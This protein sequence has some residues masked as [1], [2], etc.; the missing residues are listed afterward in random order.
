MQ[1]ERLK[2]VVLRAESQTRVLRRRNLRP[3]Q[4]V[5]RHHTTAVTATD[6]VTDPGADWETDLRTDLLT[7]LVTD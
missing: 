5:H 2:H 4:E 3:L 1:V 7:D 6:S